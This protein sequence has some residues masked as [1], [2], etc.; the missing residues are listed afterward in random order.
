MRASL[1]FIGEKYGRWTVLAEAESMRDGHRTVECRC[2]CGTV[3]VVAASDLKSGSSRSCGCLR[4]DTAARRKTTHG[5]TA[6]GKRCPEY[7][8]WKGMIQRCTNPNRNSYKQYGGRGIRVCAAWLSFPAFLKDVGP[9]HAGTTL[10]RKD[11]DGNYEPGNVRWATRQMQARNTRRTRIVVYGGVP[12]SLAAACEI[13]GV[14]YGMAV[15]RLRR[16]WPA[17]RALSPG[18]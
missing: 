15:K 11:N 3:R 10:D 18:V 4:R 9:R 6:G 16:G 17:E 12:M 7:M 5:A 14:A 8:V 1:V 13:S 2:D